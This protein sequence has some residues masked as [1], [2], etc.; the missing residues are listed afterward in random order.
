LQCEL[1]LL[2]LDL[3]VDQRADAI[4]ERLKPDKPGRSLADGGNGIRCRLRLLLNLCQRLRGR[5]LRAQHFGTEYRAVGDQVN[6]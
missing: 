6:F 2:Q 3:C 1:N 4:L 5:L